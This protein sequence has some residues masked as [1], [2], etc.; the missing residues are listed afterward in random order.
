MT[1]TTQEEN[2][3][4]KS[5]SQDDVHMPKETIGQDHRNSLLN[6]LNT[7]F[8]GRENSAELKEL[9]Q[10]RFF[11]QT[12]VLPL[13]LKNIDVSISELEAESNSGQFKLEDIFSAIESL[14]KPAAEIVNRMLA[15]FKITSTAAAMRNLFNF[16]KLPDGF[17]QNQAGE[18]RIKFSENFNPNILILPLMITLFA[19]LS[20]A[21]A[22]AN[23]QAENAVPSTPVP[24]SESLPPGQPD[25]DLTEV[26]QGTQA[27]GTATE[28]AQETEVAAQATTE[29]TV[30]S[31]TT[32]NALRQSLSIT[33]ANNFINPKEGDTFEMEV[34]EPTD[35][36][37]WTMEFITVIFRS[38]EFV[39]IGDDGVEHKIVQHD[40]GD[41]SIEIG[42]KVGDEFKNLFKLI[43]NPPT[44][45]FNVPVEVDGVKQTEVV[46][47]DLTSSVFNSLSQ[48]LK[49]VELENFTDPEP[50]IALGLTEIDVDNVHMTADVKQVENG[51]EADVV[52][53]TDSSGVVNPNLYGWKLTYNSTEAAWELAQIPSELIINLDEKIE[54]LVNQFQSGTFLN[55]LSQTDSL[56]WEQIRARTSANIE[57]AQLLQLI[58]INP[59]PAYPMNWI[60]HYDNKPEGQTKFASVI[61]GSAQHVAISFEHLDNTVTC[62]ITFA[63]NVAKEDGTTEMVQFSV[64][65]PI[66]LTVVLRQG[67]TDT[68]S[69]FP[70]LLDYLG[71]NNFIKLQALTTPES[72]LFNEKFN[73]L[74]AAYSEELEN[75]V[76]KGETPSRQF[77]ESIQFAIFLYA[78][79]Q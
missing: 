60:E 52:S 57:L 36:G 74:A 15:D 71:E 30:G 1:V 28:N 69:T 11:I 42:Y 53:F 2:L 6:R 48:F 64:N 79:G 43:Q 38:G 40:A 34:T 67:I 33:G 21:C 56:S 73:D 62:V 18:F 51:Y 75:W 24:T 39:T 66:D 20:T 65:Q 29:N 17:A 26:A 76:K 16:L 32:E 31:S 7:L 27:A 9:G 49:R 55:E 68:K 45:I 70:N 10:F 61:I 12:T 14:M 4:V 50:E 77:F 35:G 22:E 5:S 41:G 58:K 59:P 13:L 8:K 72:T 47:F 25:D 63:M 3:I 19:I 78:V 23:V 54:S 44:L 37:T 46:E